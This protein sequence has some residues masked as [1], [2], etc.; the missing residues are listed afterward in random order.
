M[1][2]VE[3]ESIFDEYVREFC[4]EDGIQES[5]LTDSEARGLKSLQKRVRKESLIVCETD[6]SGRLAV[7]SQEE[8]LEAGNKHVSKDD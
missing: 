7:M 4:D 1:R 2:R 6:K 5:N 3:W 8:Y